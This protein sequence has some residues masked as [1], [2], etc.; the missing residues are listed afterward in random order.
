MMVSLDDFFQIII[1]L[2]LIILLVSAIILIV[3]LIFTTKKVDAIVEDVDMK[4]K[5]T[6]GLFD[7]VE[8][9]TETLTSVGEIAT[10]L[11]NEKI[12]KFFKKGDE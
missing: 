4:I 1:Y 7:I 8:S 9:A 11:I 2:L 10:S 12:I 3:K 5:K 6:N